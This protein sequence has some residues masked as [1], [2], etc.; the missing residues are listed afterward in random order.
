VVADPIVGTDITINGTTITS[1]TSVATNTTILSNITTIAS[2]TSGTV[3]VIARDSVSAYSATSGL[4]SYGI[5]YQLLIVP[6]DGIALPS[7]NDTANIGNFGVIVLLSEVS[8]DYGNV[9]GFHSALT[10]AQFATIYTYQ[11]AFGVRM[12][13]LDVFPSA[14]SGTTVIAGCCG[15]GVEQLLSIT[16]DTGFETAGLKV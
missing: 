14:D 4:N 6:Q 10:A 2:S 9:T 16:D 3:L 12:V 15:A 1:N 13:R 11:L 5:P 8:Y 7:L